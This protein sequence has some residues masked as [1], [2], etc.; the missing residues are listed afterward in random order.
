[1]DLF[2]TIAH[3]DGGVVR[4]LLAADPALSRSGHD[5]VRS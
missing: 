5:G 2:E 3:G 1:M 4:D